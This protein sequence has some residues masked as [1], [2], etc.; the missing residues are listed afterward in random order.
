LRMRVHYSRFSENDAWSQR[1]G[2]AYIAT[3]ADNT[4]RDARIRI[5][6]V[7][8]PDDRIDNVYAFIDLTVLPDDGIFDSNAFP[9]SHIR[10]DDR[11]LVDHGPCR[12]RS[13]VQGT[14]CNAR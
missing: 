10:I 13:P 6:R 8:G 12:Q 11:F 4:L 7:P 2:T 1:C 3:F 14:A 9:D 5:D